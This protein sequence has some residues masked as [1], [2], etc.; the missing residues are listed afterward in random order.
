MNNSYSPKKYYKRVKTPCKYKKKV[1]KKKNV[2]NDHCKG[3][4]NFKIEEDIGN[5]KINIG[6]SIDEICYKRNYNASDKRKMTTCEKNNYMSMYIMMLETLTEYAKCDDVVMI[7]ELKRVKYILCNIVKDFPTLKFIIYGKPTDIKYP[8]SYT[9]QDIVIFKNNVKLIF[10]PIEKN[11][12]F[13]D[14][15]SKGDVSRSN[16]SYDNVIYFNLMYPNSEFKTNCD[17][18]NVI[19]ERMI[20]IFEKSMIFVKKLKPGIC[21]SE[22]KPPY[23][24]YLENNDP[25]FQFLKGTMKYSVF[26]PKTNTVT[27]IISEGCYESCLYNSEEHEMM[28]SGF[29]TVIRHHKYLNVYIN[30]CIGVDRC[31]DC[32]VTCKIIEGYFKKICKSHCNI[33]GLVDSKVKFIFKNHPDI[34]SNHKKWHKYH[35]K[36]PQ[37][38]FH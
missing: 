14:D 11:I 33:S 6:R 24:N 34:K 21:V 18:Q 1:H 22:F 17:P 31:Y 26:G 4:R 20:N 32:T 12:I 9:K 7:N 10:E 2:S 30:K 16:T 15:E 29:N 25:G 38:Y 37:K 3:L 5:V 35:K 8:Q 27:W 36:N 13:D 19:G 23:T 28:M